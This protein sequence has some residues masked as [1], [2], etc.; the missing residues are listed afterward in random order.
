MLKLSSS[1]LTEGGELLFVFNSG[2]N[3]LAF[4]KAMH[5][6]VSRIAAAEGMKWPSNS[7]QYAG[8]TDDLKKYN[9]LPLMSNE[10]IRS[11]LDS[12]AKFSL[13]DFQPCCHQRIV[14]S[15]YNKIAG[16]LGF[17]NVANICSEEALGQCFPWLPYFLTCAY[18]PLIRTQEITVTDTA[19]MGYIVMK[20]YGFCSFRCTDE[21]DKVFPEGCLAK[22]G[23]F[24]S[25]WSLITDFVGHNLNLEVQGTENFMRR[26]CKC[27]PIIGSFCCPL[28]K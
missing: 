28:S 6:S 18:Y 11:K 23:D 4:A 17:K 20:N 10:V 27:V 22:H 26:C 19:I 16:Q 1:V 9:Y 14:L 3:A 25:S 15:C 8:H 24:I 7:S 5:M 13:R 2:M 21:M 12:V